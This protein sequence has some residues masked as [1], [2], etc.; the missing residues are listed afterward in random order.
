MAFP[1]SYDS[2]DT[3]M[4]GTSLFTSDSHSLQHRTV[5]SAVIAIETF[6]G[7]NSGTNVFG[8]FTAG[9]QVLPITNGTLGTVI[10]AGSLNGLTFGSADLVNSFIAGGTFQSNIKNSGTIANGVYGTALFQGGTANNITLGTPQIN[11]GT[12]GSTAV[13][14]PLQSAFWA[15]PGTTNQVFGTNG[16]TQVHFGSKNYDLI[17]EFGTAAN[18][19]VAA[20]AGLYDFK[21]FVDVGN[22]TTNPDVQIRLNGTSQQGNAAFLGN[23]GGWAFWQGSVPAGGTIDVGFVNN[24]TTHPGTMQISNSG[25]AGF[26]GHRIL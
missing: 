15:L 25:T 21:A 24:D 12:I 1:N 11:G 20:N 14:Q 22:L 16:T 26:Y 4:V 23:T 5:A 19:F 8:G 3:T 9:Q 18:Q 6:L 2:P 17:S 13:L 10:T 7:T